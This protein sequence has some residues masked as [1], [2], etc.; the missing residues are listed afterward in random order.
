MAHVE[1]ISNVKRLIEK[2]R[3]RGTYKLQIGLV[4]AGEF[5]LRESQKLVPVDYGNLKAS[6]FIRTNGHLQ[7]TVGYTANYAVYVHEDLD[8]KHGQ[9]FNI[10][11]AAE[12]AK[13]PKHGPFRHDRGPDQNAKFL[14]MPARR[15]VPEMRA[16]I[17]GAM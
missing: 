14:E 4:L 17:R 6:A 3:K 1:G 9:S 15:Y 10:Y 16:I 7:V 11:Y 13:H 2:M 12:I 5:L 8:K